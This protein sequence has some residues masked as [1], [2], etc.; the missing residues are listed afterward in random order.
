M[1][2]RQKNTPNYRNYDN[3]NQ[4]SGP[5]G[6]HTPANHPPANPN[7]YRGFNNNN[8]YPRNYSQ[9]YPNNNNNPNHSYNRGNNQNGGGYNRPNNQYHNNNQSIPNQTYRRRVNYINA[10][11]RNNGRR[12]YRRPRSRSAEEDRRSRERAR[13]NNDSVERLRETDNNQPVNNQEAQIVR[14]NHVLAEDGPEPDTGP[15]N[16]DEDDDPRNYAARLW[17]ELVVR[18]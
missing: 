4:P 9:N 14:V 17:P 7:N 15:I 11:S 8:N 5:Q 6:N 3:R 1:L 16:E 18:W 10:E 13:F 2:N 12:G